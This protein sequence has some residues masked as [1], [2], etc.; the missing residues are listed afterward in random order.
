MTHIIWGSWYHGGYFDQLWHKTS[1]PS[2]CLTATIRVR[3]MHDRENI[4]CKCVIKYIKM[5]KTFTW[6][7]EWICGCHRNWFLSSWD[8]G[9]FREIF[10]LWL[11]W[12]CFNTGGI[13]GAGKFD[14]WTDLAHDNLCRWTAGR[15]NRP[16]HGR[17]NRPSHGRTRTTDHCYFP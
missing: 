7:H 8:W 16:S 2:Y 17:M 4:P 13:I 6:T 12:I 5:A 11:Y 3:K 15:M 1:S 9:Y 10:K 14:S